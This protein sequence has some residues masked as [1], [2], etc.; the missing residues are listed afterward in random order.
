MMK[1][2]EDAH[3][4]EFILSA[5]HFEV[6]EMAKHRLREKFS[7]LARVFQSLLPTGGIAWG[8]YRNFRKWSLHC[9]SL[10]GDGEV[11]QPTPLPVCG[12]MERI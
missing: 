12:R 5:L 9:V 2:V 7:L 11:L 4:Q 6:K 3:W 10:G 1:Q 8:R